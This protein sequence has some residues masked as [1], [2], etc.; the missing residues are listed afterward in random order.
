VPSSTPG[1]TGYRKHVI[2]R[3]P[4][5]AAQPAP[6]KSNPFTTGDVHCKQED[7]PR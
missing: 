4:G 6:D 5:A 7:T 2:A 1:L 3:C